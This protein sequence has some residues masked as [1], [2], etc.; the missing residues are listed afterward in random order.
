MGMRQVLPEKIQ[1]KNFSNI[2]NENEKKKKKKK[3]IK[4]I[5]LFIYYLFIIDWRTPKNS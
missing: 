5:Y 2:A 1:A 3:K 4:Y